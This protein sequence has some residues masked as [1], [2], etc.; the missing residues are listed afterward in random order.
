MELEYYLNKQDYIDFNIYHV[1]HSDII[2]KSLLIQRYFI[3]IIFMI[4]PFL[5]AGVT[6][7]PLLYWICV[8]IV[9]SVVWIVFYP[10]Y[11]VWAFS[12]RVSKMV[13]EGKNKDLLGKHR[14]TVN[15]EGVLEQSENGENKISW[16][17]VEKIVSSNQHIF[18][19]IGSISACIIPKRAFKTNTDMELFHEYISK[20]INNKRD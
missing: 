20:Y 18:I 1:N 11:F 15:E 4:V 16:S 19:Y 5:I 12:K 9:I 8:F 6:D 3:P 14:V 7:L 17:G 10:K 2:K 13:D